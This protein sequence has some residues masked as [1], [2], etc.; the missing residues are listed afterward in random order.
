M[1]VECLFKS[2]IKKFQVSV[3]QV[4]YFK[5]LLQDA[6][7]DIEEEENLRSLISRKTILV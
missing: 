5:S 4:D 3:G 7:L 1:T 2:R 6:N